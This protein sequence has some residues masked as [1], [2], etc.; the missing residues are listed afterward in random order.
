MIC[1]HFTYRLIYFSQNPSLSNL[2]KEPFNGSFCE[3][4]FNGSFCE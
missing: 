1:S 4:S 3:Q 2:S